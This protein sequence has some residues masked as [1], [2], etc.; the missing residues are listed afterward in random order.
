MAAAASTS[1]ASTCTAVF[2]LTHGRPTIICP[3]PQRPSISSAHFKASWGWSSSSSPTWCSQVVV[4]ASSSSDESPVDANEL[5]EDLKQ[6]W[7]AVENKPTVILYGSGAIVALWFASVVVGAINSIPLVP[8]MMELVGL[9][10]AGWFVYRYLLFKSS[11][12]EL[13]TDIEALKKKISGADQ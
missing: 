8:K 3:L 4:K 11:R 7:D 6:K 1:M 2:T 12:K 9:G 5:I 10:Y 13:A